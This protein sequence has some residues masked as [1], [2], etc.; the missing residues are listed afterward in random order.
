MASARKDI[1]NSI[2][3]MY[4]VKIDNFSNKEKTIKETQ[5]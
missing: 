4:N 2:D 1:N 5:E 3:N